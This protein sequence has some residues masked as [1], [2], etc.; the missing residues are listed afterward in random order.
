MLTT[1]QLCGLEQTHI[2]VDGDGHGLQP[3]C[4]AGWH[5]LQARAR[6]RGFDLQI[7]SAF[8]S[9]ERQASIWNRKARGELAL[10]D[11]AGQVLDGRR[12]T[13]RQRLHA[14]LRFSALPGAS[15]HHWGTDLD[16]C[17]AAAVPAD[18]A[19]QLTAAEA[20]PDGVFGPLH[21][22][23]D[24]QLAEGGGLGFFRPYDR[25]RGGVAPEPWHLSFRPLADQ[26]Q[27][28]MSLAGLET[29]LADA[30][31]ELKG[32]LLPLLPEIYQRYIH[33]P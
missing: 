19:V 17:D 13:A 15:R 3:D 5:E 2:E 32:E 21:Q 8:R 24:Q 7:V 27:R 29:V 20:A 26:C 22:W 6:E 10:L 11:D 9:F 28:A 33:L 25:D 31:L 30:E 14:I 4:R 16:I 23:L 18:Y 12:L 1:R